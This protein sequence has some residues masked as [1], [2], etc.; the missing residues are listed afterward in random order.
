MFSDFTSTA[1]IVVPVV[2]V[3]AGGILVWI[4]RRPIADAL[5][6][7]GSTVSL[8]GGIN[9]TV[10]QEALPAHAS[11]PSATSPPP[12]APLGSSLPEYPTKFIG[13]TGQIEYV[14]RLL[15]DTRLLTLTGV[16]GCG[17][18]R[19]AVRVASEIGADYSGGVHFVDLGSLT[20]PALVGPAVAKALGVPEAPELSLFD[21]LTNAVKDRRVL[22]VLDNCEHVANECATLIDMLLS[23]CPGVRILATSRGPLKLER[24]T[25][26]AV[27]P[28][29]TVSDVPGRRDADSDAVL[30]FV[31]SARRKKPDFELTPAATT[32]VAEICVQLDGLPLAIEMAAAAI[33]MMSVDDVLHDLSAILNVPSNRDPGRPDRHETIRATMEWSY[34]LLTPASRSLFA[35]LSG[36]AGTF[37]LNTAK[38]LCDSMTPMSLEA[39]LSILSTLVDSS[40]LSRTDANMETNYR[41]LRTVK[42]FAS[43][44]LDE[45]GD[46]AKL[47][48][49]HATHFMSLVEEAE[50]RLTS[51]DRLEWFAR[52][53]DALD[54]IR[55]AFLWLQSAS[56]HESALRLSGS[57]FWFWNLRGYFDEGR[58]YLEASL[59]ASQNRGQSFGRAIALYAAGGFAFLQGDI[60]VARVD[61]MES[62]RIWRALNDAR[63]LGFSLAVL[64]MV[65]LYCDELDEARQNEE[66]AVA[67]FQGLSHEWGLALALNDLGNVVV[68]QGDYPGGRELFE[69]SL[70]LW[71]ALKDPWGLPLVLDNV[72]LLAIR[73]HDEAAAETALNRARALHEAAADRW[74]GAISLSGLARLALLRR[75]YGLAANLFAE[76]LAVHLEFGRKEQVAVCMAGLGQVSAEMG[77]WECAARLFG[78]TDH[79]RERIAVRLSSAERAEYDR[80]VA[81]AGRITSRELYEEALAEGRHMTPE[82]A[83]ELCS[84]RLSLLRAPNQ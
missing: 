13:R 79:L 48:R 77:E 34:N 65:H 33:R 57:L 58:R 45:S 81:D 71:E 44:R 75:D 73:Q 17:K 54:D 52:V 29:N 70:H 39:F 7:P 6:K 62:V 14:K 21:T 74:G 84:A 78:A 1:E 66:E 82:D 60:R 59:H 64:G 83:I 24:E 5:S 36:F 56:D 32:V 25:T 27:P 28:L 43:E 68:A 3:I 38:T 20:D 2:A 55:A 18:T 49:A 23:K 46:A 61:L 9:V 47:R 80:H 10:G 26:W 40:L 51:R 76:S 72:G 42:S 67:V 35:W 8:P 50:P 30:L 15:L 19:L 63:H 22:L 11:L 37:N 31:E 12:S 41:M 69:Q 16:G 4:L 53:E